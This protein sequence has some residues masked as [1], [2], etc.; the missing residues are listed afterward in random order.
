MGMDPGSRIEN[1]CMMLGRSVWAFYLFINYVINLGGQQLV[2]LISPAL[3]L[4]WPV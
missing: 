2:A 3:P 4:A 1:A